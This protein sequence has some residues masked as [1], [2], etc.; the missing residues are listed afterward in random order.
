MIYSK[1]LIKT[2]TQLLFPH[3]RNER[4][5]VSDANY[6][7]ASYFLQRRF[8]FIGTFPNRPRNKGRSAGFIELVRAGT[9]TPG[10]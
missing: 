5:A 9:L 4:H 7:P 1:G 2:G 10:Y 8:D 6:L 3:R